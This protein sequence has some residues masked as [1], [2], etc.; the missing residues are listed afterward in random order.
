MLT[1]MILLGFQLKTWKWDDILTKGIASNL[2][3][4]LKERFI[5]ST[6]S[7]FEKEMMVGT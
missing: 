5:A 7:A 2:C 6:Y 4:A 1:V 3:N